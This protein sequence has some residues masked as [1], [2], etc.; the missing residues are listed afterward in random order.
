MCL[1]LT[2]GKESWLTPLAVIDVWAS[3]NPP[4]MPFFD[5]RQLGKS[6]VWPILRASSLQFIIC[7]LWR[8]FLFCSLFHLKI[9][10][11][12]RFCFLSWAIWE[13]R[14]SL[15]N[16]GTSKMPEIV[17]SGADALLAEFQNSRL[18]VHTRIPSPSPQICADWIAPLLGKLK[19]NTAVACRLNSNSAGVGAAIRDD[20]GRVLVAH[21]NQLTGHFRAEVG[22]LLAIREGFKLA[23]FYNLSVNSVEVASSRAASFLSDPDGSLG[24]SKLIAVDIKAFL[25]DAGICKVQAIPKSGNSLALK[26]AHL[27]FSSV[28]ELLWLDTSPVFR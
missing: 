19:L 26:L 5:A 7:R 18:A 27:A 11:L 24:L 14:N 3:R 10:D 9:D 2:C 8:G 23:K 22:E 16:C 15:V 12:C 1:N 4:L 13:N 20:K 25:F 6:G 28:K 21:S 17:V